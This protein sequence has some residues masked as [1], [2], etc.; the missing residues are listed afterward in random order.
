MKARILIV[1]GWFIGWLLL[2]RVRRLPEREASEGSGD[3]GPVT[4][5]IEKEV[6]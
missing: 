2:T 6:S 5:V 3:D 4:I 1:L